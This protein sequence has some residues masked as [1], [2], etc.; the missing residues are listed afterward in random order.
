MATNLESDSQSLGKSSTKK[1]DNSSDLKNFIEPSISI[2][3]LVQIDLLRNGLKSGPLLLQKDTTE[4]VENA[5]TNSKTLKPNLDII[6]T[7]SNQLNYKLL[8]GNKNKIIFKYFFVLDLNTFYFQFCKLNK[9][10]PLYAIK[11]ANIPADWTNSD[12]EQLTLEININEPTKKVEIPYI[13][14]QPA[15]NY[16][17][18]R[19]FTR[20]LNSRALFDRVYRHFVRVLFYEWNVG[21]DEKTGDHKESQKYFEKERTCDLKDNKLKIVLRFKVGFLFKKKYYT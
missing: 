5:K 16:L 12:L 4:T 13:R 9:K 19:H 2:Q 6:P 15:P 8:I 21:G 3:S 10:Q 18:R 11:L 17:P 7:L 1:T 20:F 14:K